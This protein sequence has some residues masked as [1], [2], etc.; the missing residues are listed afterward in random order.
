MNSGD[1]QIRNR[2]EDQGIP[3]QLSSENAP[4]LA[5]DGDNGARLVKISARPPDRP[6]FNDG[7]AVMIRLEHFQPSL[8]TCRSTRDRRTCSEGWPHALRH[9]EDGWPFTIVKG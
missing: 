5:P 4:T 9:E 2:P 7:G 3:V 1:R 8:P 6:Y